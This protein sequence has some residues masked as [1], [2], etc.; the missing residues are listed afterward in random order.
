MFSLR[1]ALS[2]AA[3]VISNI[4]N[5]GQ[6]ATQQIESD[7]I[8]E[9]KITR[10]LEAGSQKAVE[11]VIKRGRAMTVDFLEINASEQADKAKQGF[12]SVSQE[13]KQL[14]TTGSVTKEQWLQ[15][16]FKARGITRTLA[17]SNPLIDFDELLFVK[18][19]TPNFGHQCAHRVGESQLPG[20][21]LCIL[22][23]L[24]PDG[25]VSE[26]LSG[27][28]TEGGIGRP[29]LS[30]DGKRIVFPFAR[31]R[32]KDRA[33]RFSPAQFGGTGLCDMYDIYEIDI[34]GSN[35]KQITKDM[36]SEDTEP[37]YLPGGRIAFTSSRNKR[38]VQ[39]GD[40]ALVNGIYSINP[41][42]TGI[43]KITEPQ[44]GEFY[45]SILEDG[46]IMYTRWDYVMKPYNTQQQLWAVNPDGRRSEL[47]YGD[48]YRFSTGPIA[49]FEGRQIPGTSKIMATGAAHH[50]ICVGPIMIVDMNQNRGG[51]DG[52]FKVTPEV[53]YPEV[54]RK[55][56]GSAN[57]SKTG[58]YGAPYPLSEKHFI[59]NYSF[60]PRTT[61]NYGI[62]LMDIHGNREL[63]YR[64]GDNDSC[65]APMPLRP[66][67]EPLV[68]PNLVK[69][70][71][72][73]KPATLIVNDVYQGL[74]REGV[75]RG[76]VKYLRVL[77]V[78]P[79]I[80]H[81]EAQRIDVGVNS[82]WDMRKVL[83]TVPVE[84]DGS[85]HF[86]LPPHKLILLEALDKDYL[87]IKRMRNY[88][89]VKPGEVVSCIGCHEPY[90]MS[91]P[92]MPQ[93]PT[94]LRRAPSQIKSP[95][96]GIRGMS[97]KH[98]VQPVLDKH[99]ISCHDGSGGEEKAFSLSGEKMITAEFGYDRD[100]GPQHAVSESFLK[101]LNYVKYVQVGSYGNHDP[102]ILFP[103]PANSIGSRASKLMKILKKGHKEVN[104]NIDEWRAFAAW[105]DCNAP[106]YGDFSDVVI[107]EDG[108]DKWTSR[109]LRKR[110]IDSKCRAALDKKSPS[111]KL[112]N[113]P[114][115]IKRP[116]P[117]CAPQPKSDQIKKPAPKCAPQPKNDQVGI[118]K[119]LTPKRK[120]K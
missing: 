28:F 67:K 118:I 36:T 57:K 2:I 60:G 10:Q 120:K 113:R 114:A 95:A 39:C 47:V 90:G 35:I 16:Y 48:Y 85:I 74:L 89:N 17:F 51:P 25:K 54:Q 100:Y 84:E 58:W 111:T 78:L 41:D 72:N 105:I 103:S 73:D 68:I 69:G 88:I 11:E 70:V 26:I 81:T 23:G 3:L 94:A 101:L 61:S 59:V 4:A 99:C 29:D 82:G 24:S 44:D 38:M 8:Q 71:P 66:R 31:K 110:K 87:E 112:D 97:F 77:E 19:K 91:P 75:K 65:Y 22:K 18:R 12:D 49:L 30:F 79:K 64:L 96:W 20:S 53:H 43:Y 80:Q 108:K 83:G 40:W 27:E 76:E 5:G 14:I 34:S 104:L 55:G 52:M 6:T 115:H 9:E 45:P 109:K 56:G 92:N 37:C 119:P 32:A 50:N 63:I 7:W 107:L 15:L 93:M 21:N 62:Y 116:V 33:K 117:K 1:S 13:L 46:R 102:S 98:V 86:Q 42:G 106:Y